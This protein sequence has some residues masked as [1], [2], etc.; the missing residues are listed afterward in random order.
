M[1]LM[2]GKD[3]V[4]TDCPNCHAHVTTI[5]EE[6]ISLIAWVAAGIMFFSCVLCLCSPIPL[7]MDSLRD[8]KHYCPECRAIVGRY[9]AKL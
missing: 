3:P 9:K 6:E 2:F 8:V 4:A 7:V 5:A 1:S